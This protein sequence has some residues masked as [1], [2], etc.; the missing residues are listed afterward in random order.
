[1]NE[2][3]TDTKSLNLAQNKAA[4]FTAEQLSRVIDEL[5]YN[6]HIPA[7]YDGYYYLKSAITHIVLSDNKL[8]DISQRLTAQIAAEYGT[9]RRHVER[10]MAKAADRMNR[11]LGGNNI[12]KAVTGYE[13]DCEMPGLNVKELIALTADQ[14]KIK[15][16][17]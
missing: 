9:D 10:S 15:Y 8:P 5:F 12:I 16:V 6:L 3:L 11:A 13:T 14:L 2:A 4:V 17:E 1:M 7:Y